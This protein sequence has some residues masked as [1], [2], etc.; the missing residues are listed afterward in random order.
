[1]SSRKELLEFTEFVRRYGAETLGHIK[2]TEEG[3]HS[4][5]LKYMES[6]MEQVQQ[7]LCVQHGSTIFLIAGDADIVNAALGALRVHVAKHYGLIP[8]GVFNFLWVTEFP[9]FEQDK[10]TGRWVAC[11]HPFTAVHEDD[12]MMMEIDKRNVRARAYDLVLNGTEIGGGSIR[13]HTV[14]MQEKMFRCIGFSEEMAEKQFG[15]FLEALRYGTPPH[16]GIA[17]GFDRI[18]ALLAGKESI[19]DV[20]PFPKTQK[21]TCLL[22]NAPSTVSEE[23]LDEIHI[24][25]RNK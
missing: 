10:E 19:R 14:Q 11:H 24:A 13:N 2:Y 22:T 18:V 20:I 6:V 17:F 23:Q 4:P 8:E 12:A 21:A 15:Y 25:V 16:G 1:M 3:W 5:L 9:L 7:R